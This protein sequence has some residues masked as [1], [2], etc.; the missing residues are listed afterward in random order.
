MLDILVAGVLLVLLAPLLLAIALAIRLSSSGP[1]LFVQQRAG[2]G[3]KPFALYKFR[4]MRLDV[5]PFGPSPKSPEDPRL[6]RIG[7]WLRERSLDELPQLVNVLKGDM[8]LVGPRPLY[9]SQVAEW[10]ER[11]RRRL[12]VRPGLTGLAQV[13]GRGALTREE[14]LECDVQYV[15]QVSLRLD[16]VI[17][18]KTL[19]RLCGR[20]GIYEKRYS[21]D[22]SI[23]GEKT[24]EQAENRTNRDDRP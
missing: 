15:E 8:S 12:S 22:E 6:T 23:R 21:Q 7:R 20:R 19:A 4:T 18:L 24:L 14:K 11:Q 17:L 5:E 3:G 16:A 10:N 1:A 9:V 2:K 13:S